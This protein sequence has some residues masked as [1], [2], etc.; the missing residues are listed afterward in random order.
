MTQP[1]TPP[2]MITPKHR[3]AVAVWRLFVKVLGTALFV[4]IGMTAWDRYVD[5]RRADAA[6]E[7]VECSRRLNA[8]VLNSLAEN[9]AGISAFVVDLEQSL[10][11]APP[12]TVPGQLT[13]DEARTLMSDS[14]KD[15]LVAAREYQSFSDNPGEKCPRP[16]P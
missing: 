13:I 5:N 3:D 7:D 9:Q 10:S 8:E 16:V 15:L 12:P 11:D 4:Y 14:S 2:P 6:Q 1:T